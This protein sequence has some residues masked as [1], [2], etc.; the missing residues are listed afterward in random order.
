MQLRHFC[1][2]PGIIPVLYSNNL[3][4]THL[5]TGN[6]GIYRRKVLTHLPVL[7][8]RAATEVTTSPEIPSIYSNSA[9]F[10]L[11]PTL[12]LFA[13]AGFF[14][15]LFIRNF[16][17]FLPDPSMHQLNIAHQGYRLRIVNPFSHH[18]L[19]FTGPKGHVRYAH[20]LEY[21]ERARCSLLSHDG[22]YICIT[23]IHPLELNHK[24]SWISQVI[25]VNIGKSVIDTN[26]IKT[27]L[28]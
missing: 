15:D 4:D 26:R 13:V 17:A 24:N 14:L 22:I 10:Q 20:N 11:M 19:Q 27:P 8:I 16:F 6:L 7:L 21:R 18:G 3:R 2:I 25:A 12:G 9:G 1:G 23:N 28:G 5:T